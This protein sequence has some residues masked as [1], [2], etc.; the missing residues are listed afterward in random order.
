LKN[1]SQVIRRMFVHLLLRT[2]LRYYR[3]YLRHHFD[4][5]V[6]LE[7]GAII[8]VLFYLAGRSP[9]DMG[10]SLKFLLAK[11]FPFQYAKQ[12]V[13]ALPFFYLIVE[14]LALVT[15]RSTGEWQILGALP[16]PKTAVTNYHLLR[17]SGKTAGLLLVGTLPFWM[18]EFSLMEKLARFFCALG[19]LLALQFAGFTQAHHLRN[20]SKELPQRLLLWLPIET[21]IIAVLVIG[22][23]I[24]PNLLIVSIGNTL[25]GLLAG[26]SLAV[27]A[28]LHIRR[29]YEP[30]LIENLASREPKII[31]TTKLLDKF[32]FGEGI[33]G[34][35]IQRDLKFLWMEKRSAFVW[36]AGVTAILLAACLAQSSAE[37]AY[38]SSIV[39]E[40]IFSIILINTLLILFE[41]DVQ[42]FGVTRVLPVNAKTCWKSRWL[43]AVGFMAAPT[44]ALVL[45]IPLKFAI[46]AGFLFF[47]L[48]ALLIPAV[49]AA[50]FCNAGFGLFP[51]LKFCG[52]LLNIAL[53]LMILFWFYMPFGSLLLLAI[54]ALWIRKSQRHFQLLEIQ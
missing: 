10:Y 54:S 43:L 18:G 35:L 37:E 7:M 51:N 23:V 39:I 8:L 13:G 12:W 4:R 40:A 33:I 15:L 42:S 6:W 25:I 16:V 27:V 31:R 29:T 5:M 34:A 52:V 19:S 1:F 46:G 38:A 49:F 26:W 24:L 50:M 36:L 3:N 53:G 47:V 30:G 41:Q 11:E 22:H 9:A 48:L 17:H 21:A 45:M 32:C 28:F 20:T 2:R 14:A 44:T